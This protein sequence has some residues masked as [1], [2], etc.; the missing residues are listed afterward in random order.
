MVFEHELA[1]AHK[2][3]NLTRAGCKRVNKRDYKR[4]Y[5]CLCKDMHKSNAHAFREL[6]KD[7]MDSS[8][9]CSLAV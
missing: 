7:C 1:S 8:V 2:S 3:M 6:C 9:S 4:V 5:K